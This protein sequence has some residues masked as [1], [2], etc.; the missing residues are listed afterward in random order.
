[1]FELIPAVDVLDGSVVRLVQGSFEDVT[2]YAANP[3]AVARKFVEAGASLVHVVDLNGARSGSVDL[4][5]AERLA[6]AGVPYQLGGGIRDAAT[7]S[8]VVETG[9]SRVVCG[10]AAVWDPEELRR[11]L[12]AV[13]EERVVGAVDVASGMAR[14]GA[15]MDQGRPVATVMDGAVAAGLQRALVTSIER[16]GVLVGPDIELLRIAVASGLE[17][18]ASGGV[19]SLD[20]L[21]SV[22]AVGCS[23]A[24]V[25]R[26]LYEGRF[27]LEAALDRLADG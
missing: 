14:G 16:D 20:D 12:E 22:R 7:A 13:G 11:I 2:K 15:W 4:S 6:A 5:L 8:A 10:S 26:A 23:G 24:I 19:T 25:G 17:I 9:A 18:V 1:M 21:V 3:V 27:T